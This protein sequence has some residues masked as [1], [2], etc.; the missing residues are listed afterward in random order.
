MENYL[1]A[2][3]RIRTLENAAVGA[4][5]LE[6]LLSCDSVADC[7]LR[8]E[9]WGITVLRTPDGAFDREATLEKRLS[10]AYAEVLSSPEDAGFARLWLLPYD[11]C[12][13]KSAIKCRK[14]GISCEPMLIPIYGGIPTDTVRRAIERRDYACLPASLAIA[15]RTAAEELAQTS[16]PRCVDRILDA[17][18]YAEM[19]RLAKESGIPLAKRLVRKRIDLTN[20]MLTLR[21]SRMGGTCAM[22]T[23][24]DFFLAGGEIDKKDLTEWMQAG[25]D[26]LIDRL[27]YTP[28]EQFSKRARETD[29]SLVQLERVAD[30]VLMEL[31][32]EAKAIPLGAEVLI[33]FL[34]GRE[35]EVKNLRILLAGKSIGL[36]AN[37]LRERMRLS[38]V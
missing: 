9:E 21:V 27:Y 22:Q 3:A 4:E 35:Y 37:A 11:C 5:R 18:C 33:G 1:Y 17:A 31:A 30:D 32:R 20:I 25:T 38:Y 7:V 8:L 2:G 24:D 19:L 26:V 13:V 34:I 16:D 28:C 15:A 12:N 6:H 10:D 14:R 36:D 23:L 29:L